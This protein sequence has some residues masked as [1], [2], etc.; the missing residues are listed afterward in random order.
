MAQKHEHKSIVD[1]QVRQLAGVAL[2]A[3]TRL[4]RRAAGFAFSQV[5]NSPYVG[6]V[7]PGAGMW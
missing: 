2:K 3:G 6:A 7:A 4:M 1:Y 5:M